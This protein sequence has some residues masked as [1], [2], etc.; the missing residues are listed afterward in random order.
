MATV[1]LDMPMA[2][3]TSFDVPRSRRSSRRARRAWICSTGV[4]TCRR[5]ISAS[6]LGFR[7]MTRSVKIGAMASVILT[8]ALRP[9]VRHC[10]TDQCR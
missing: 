2:R 3:A 7:Q 9:K 6:V 1:A 8:Q 5:R 10:K 4:K